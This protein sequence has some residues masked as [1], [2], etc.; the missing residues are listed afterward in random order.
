MFA[1]QAFGEVFDSI[2]R[3][4]SFLG[5]A[6]FLSKLTEV[7]NLTCVENGDSGLYIS[8]GVIQEIVSSEFS[9]NKQHGIFIEDPTDI[10][11]SEGGETPVVILE[12]TDVKVEENKFSGLHFQ[13]VP[14]TFEST[15]QTAVKPEL[16]IS[17]KSFFNRNSLHGLNLIGPMSL[18]IDSEEINEN[19][20][21][22]IRAETKVE[23]R[24]TGTK[25]QSNGKGDLSTDWKDG[26]LI[27]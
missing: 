20:A 9:K 1:N 8:F 6:V 18:T 4:N 3:E 16:K 2:C 5:L 24:V 15:S 27:N 12:L 7:R 11:L 26:F 10:R 14:A 19:A 17:G 25:L 22:G 23:G 13:I 21:F